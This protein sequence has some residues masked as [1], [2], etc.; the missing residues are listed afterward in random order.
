MNAISTALADRARGTASWR[1]S[2][3][4]HSELAGVV[5]A[6]RAP[7]AAELAAVRRSVR[8]MHQQ[9]HLYSERTD[10]QALVRTFW[11][12]G[13]VST[14]ARAPRAFLF[15]EL[16]DIVLRAPNGPAREAAIRQ[17]AHLREL[18][19]TML[20][21]DK[22]ALQALE[23]HIQPGLEGV[24]QRVLI[25]VA[26]SDANGA[27]WV[28]EIQALATSLSSLEPARSLG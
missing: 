12:A 21:R 27:W 28:V 10:K 26:Q 11:L 8:R 22:H 16:D 25:E 6:T 4:T 19:E 2:A 7:D 3:L 24:L 14:Y 15:D 20:R 18:H 5:Y 17:L 13:A 9:G 1:E 23:R